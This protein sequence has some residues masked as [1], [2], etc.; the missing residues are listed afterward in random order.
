MATSVYFTGSVKSE[1]NLYEDL[2]IESLQLYGQD[3]VYIPRKEITHDEILNESYSKFT[4]I[5]QIEMYIENQDGFEGDGD[6]LSKF[7]LEI[8][9]QATFIVSKRRWEKQVGTWGAALR[10]MEGDLLFLPMANSIFEIRFVEHESPFY[11]LQNVPVYKLQAE[12]FEYSDEVLDTG[13]GA[14]DKIETVNATA[15]SY[16]L[17]SGSG[18]FIVGETVSQWSGAYELDDLGAPDLALPINIEGEVASWEDTGAGGNLMVVSHGTTDGK[19]RKFYA[20]TGNLISGTE[21][22]ATYECAGDLA[23]SSNFNDSYADNDAFE[24][25]ADSIIDFTE[26]NPFG[27]P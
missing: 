5:Y 17:I 18:R 15:Y 8:R 22:G 11:Q 9:D 23:G 26:N 14:I 10:P 16:L 3:I 20:D 13:I 19:F 4:D 25:E 27:M 24:Y 2:I 6:L 1:Q 21:S 12:L 7:G